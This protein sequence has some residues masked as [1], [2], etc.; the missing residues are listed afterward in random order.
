[1]P[2]TPRGAVCLRY[3]KSWKHPILQQT[4]TVELQQFSL[5]DGDWADLVQLWNTLKGVLMTTLELLH[6]SF[7]TCEAKHPRNYECLS[8][9][10][11]ER[12]GV[13]NEAH[14]FPPQRS[15]MALA[16]ELT[17]SEEEV[18][19]PVHSQDKLF[20][21]A[22]W[23]YFLEP[24]QVQDKR[25]PVQVQQVRW[26][27]QSPHQECELSDNAL[28]LHIVHKNMIGVGLQNKFSKSVEGQWVA[29]VP[30]SRHSAETDFGRG[31]DH[32][33]CHSG[34]LVYHQLPARS[35]WYE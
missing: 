27:G 5:R 24:R 33:C 15:E 22:V 23:F 6:W 29:H 1:M 26:V 4:A 28:V 3:C 17:V 13:W 16:T 32:G 14:D 35:W 9:A 12:C 25:V 20:Q 18:P 30:N 21:N 2:S 34:L 7:V 11:I 10:K 19:A 8:S 31:P